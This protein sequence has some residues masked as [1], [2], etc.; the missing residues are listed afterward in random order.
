MNKKE[1]RIVHG[2]IIALEILLVILVVTCRDCKCKDDK[3]MQALEN[4][5]ENNK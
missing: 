3:G 2:I 4:R 5:I 1:S